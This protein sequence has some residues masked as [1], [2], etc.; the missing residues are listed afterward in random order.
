MFRSDSY[1]TPSI[2]HLPSIPNQSTDFSVTVSKDGSPVEKAVVCA[3]KSGEV[4][5]VDLTDANGVVVLNISPT[6]SGEMTI[7]VTGQNIYPQESGVTIN[8]SHSP[9]PT[10]FPTPTPVPQDVPKILFSGYLDTAIVNYPDSSCGRINMLMSVKKADA[11]ISHAGLTYLPND[12]WQAPEYIL[13]FDPVAGK[14]GFYSYYDQLLYNEPINADLDF[15]MAA[16]D[17]NGLHSHHWPYVPVKGIITNNSV[18]GDPIRWDQLLVPVPDAELTGDTLLAVHKVIEELHSLNPGPS[19]EP[20]IWQ[21]GYLDTDLTVGQPG[22]LKIVAVVSK[23]QD[24]ASIAKLELYDNEN[25]LIH[26]LPGPGTEHLGF[27]FFYAEYTIPIVP[28][29]DSASSYQWKMRAVDMN[30]NESKLWPK[31]PKFTPQE[32]APIITSAHFGDAQCKVNWF[33]DNRIKISNFKVSWINEETYAMGNSPLLGN[34]QTNYTIDGLINCAPYT[35]W[36][37][38]YDLC[39]NELTSEGVT[40]TPSFLPIPQNVKIVANAASPSRFDITWDSTGGQYCALYRGSDPDQMYFDSIHYSPPIHQPLIDGDF[41]TFFAVKTLLEPKQP[42]DDDFTSCFSNVVMGK[43]LPPGILYPIQKVM[44]IDLLNNGLDDLV[45][46]MVDET[47]LLYF[48]ESDGTWTLSNQTW[49][50][51]IKDF[52][53]LDFNGDGYMDL[54]LAGINEVYTYFNVGNGVMNLAETFFPPGRNH[55]IHSD[56]MDTGDTSEIIVGNTRGTLIKV[57]DTSGLTEA[58]QNLASGNTQILLTVDVTGDGQKEL[59]TAT[60]TG[61][62]DIWSKTEIGLYH[63][64]QRLHTPGITSIQSEDVTENGCPDLIV[65]DGNGNS[66]VFINDCNGFFTLKR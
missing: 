15:G 61:E 46:L 25:R 1:Y 57:Y 34:T 35:I 42:F 64:L 52:T 40:G 11:S 26:T 30:G 54:S 27:Y 17:S 39:G 9:T 24:G 5:S 32:S 66:I 53:L 12:P 7:T 2:V 43:K 56:K 6:S 45:V 59:I 50:S 47:I 60:I 63:S 33:Q 4:H 31:V 10:P 13:Y 21:A 18:P 65:I 16:T 38:A 55:V 28:E 20:I 22:T 19:A 49:P 48:G 23:N 36:I 58:Y 62:I 41:A 51:L 29:P 8:H 44:L 14:D 3:Y 37:K